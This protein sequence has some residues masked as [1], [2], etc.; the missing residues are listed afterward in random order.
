MT[1]E[2]R[3]VWPSF[4]RFD[5]GDRPSDRPSAVDCLSRTLPQQAAERVLRVRRFTPLEPINCAGGVKRGSKE[6]E[7]YGPSLSTGSQK[8]DPEQISGWLKVGN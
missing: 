8:V 1:K 7:P 2:N 3:L 4:R 6:I 5:R